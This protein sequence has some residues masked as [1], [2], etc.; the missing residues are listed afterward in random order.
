MR[1]LDHNPLQPQLPHPRH[2]AALCHI[3]R[4]L[5]HLLVVRLLVM[6]AVVQLTAVGVRQIIHVKVMRRVLCFLLLTQRRPFA[7][8]Q[9]SHKA[10]PLKLA[11]YQYLRRPPIMP[12]R[13]SDSDHRASR[14]VQA[15]VQCLQMYHRSILLTNSLR[16]MILVLILGS[17][18]E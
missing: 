15:Q 2:K 13:A 10:K 16:M 12:I 8:A 11:C 1:C 17:R 18:N 5:L 4:P 6:L 3:T 9:I 14:L 7:Q